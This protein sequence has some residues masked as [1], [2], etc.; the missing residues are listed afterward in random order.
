M[1]NYYYVKINNEKLTQEAAAEIFD[2]LSKNCYVRYFN[3]GDGGHISYNTRG[4]IDIRSVLEKYYVDEEEMEIEDEFERFYAS[5]TQEEKDEM[6]IEA[7]KWY[8]ENHPEKAIARGF[9]F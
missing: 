6:A 5:L 8:S 1:A 3:Y 9:T 7:Q 2:I 4:L